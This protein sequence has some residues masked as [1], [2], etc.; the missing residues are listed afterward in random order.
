MP[1]WTTGGTD[2]VCEGKKKQTG[3]ERDE[4]KE[5]GG[6]GEGKRKTE[7]EGEKEKRNEARLQG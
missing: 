4:M 6:G 2:G 3:E 7:K 1:S 5:K